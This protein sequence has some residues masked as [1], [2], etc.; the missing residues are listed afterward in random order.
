MS[1]YV[2]KGGWGG[3]RSRPERTHCLRGHPLVEE[4]LEKIGKD[5]RR[6][7]RICRNE[8]TR[9]RYKPFLKM[10]KKGEEGYRYE[11]QVREMT[12]VELAYVA[13]WLEGEGTFL[14]VRGRYPRVVGGSTDLDTLENLQRIT[15]VGSIYEQPRHPDRRKTIWYWH[16]VPF[17]DAATLMRLLEPHMMS[18]RAAKIRKILDIIDCVE[19]VS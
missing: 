14:L 4:N 19:E 11:T 10:V 1:N 9:A 2:K 8:R 15:G 18:R 7:C 13:G 12:E 17:N 3:A 6:R 16:V 5:G